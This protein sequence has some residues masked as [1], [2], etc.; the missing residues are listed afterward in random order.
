MP[1]KSVSVFNEKQAAFPQLNQQA[2][3]LYY[4]TN[5]CRKNP[6]RFW[7]SIMVPV[8]QEHPTWLSA[9]TK[10]LQQDLYNTPPLALLS[11]NR[12]LIKIAQ[13]HA[14]DIGLK[15]AKISHNST[16]G[17]SF[18]DRFRQTGLK[19]CGGEN[20]A[21][22]NKDPL[23]ALIDLLVDEKVVDLGHRKAILSKQYNLIGLGVSF[24][25]DTK[26]LF[27]VQ[28]FACQQ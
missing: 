8:L 25:S 18:F 28:D 24:I 22:G 4:W 16:D 5:Y 10:S 15:G 19:N 1:D 21:Y 2:K 20:L 6:R 11:L 12:E 26:T 7:D 9:Y 17:R 13:E 23:L 3:T 14:N 27:S